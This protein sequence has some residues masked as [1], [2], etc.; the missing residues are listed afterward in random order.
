MGPF[1][2]T[3]WPIFDL[4]F[5]LSWIF[6]GFQ[7]FPWCF[8]VLSCGRVSFTHPVFE[9]EPGATRLVARMLAVGTS[10][11]HFSV[12]SSLLKGFPAGFGAAKSL[13]AA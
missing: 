5:V 6:N 8:N 1:A 11:P 13:K 12:L 4:F 9:K 2:S 3:F 10:D 7:P